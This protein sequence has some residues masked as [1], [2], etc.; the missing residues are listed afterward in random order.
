MTDRERLVERIQ[1]SVPPRESEWAEVIADE[2]LAD[3][4]MRPPCKVGQTVYQTQPT[5]NR[6]Q[7]YEV[8]A[9]KFNGSC[10][11]FSWVLKDGKGFYVIRI[12]KVQRI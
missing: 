5:R 12:Q 2:L 10:Y 4:W 9:L 8:T 6:V 3:G 1:I 7:E 11:F